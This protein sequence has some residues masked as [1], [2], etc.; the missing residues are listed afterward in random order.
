MRKDHRRDN[1]SNRVPLVP[2]RA[3]LFGLDV[4][5]RYVDEKLNQKKLKRSALN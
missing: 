4:R 5:F 3:A 2:I 1:E